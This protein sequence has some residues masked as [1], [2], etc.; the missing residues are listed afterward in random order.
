MHLTPLRTCRLF[1]YYFL[2]LAPCELLKGPPALALVPHM[3]GI[4][5]LSYCRHHHPWNLACTPSIAGVTYFESPATSQYLQKGCLTANKRSKFYSRAGPREQLSNKKRSSKYLDE[6]GKG[7]LQVWD[8]ARSAQIWQNNK[9]NFIVSCPQCDARRVKFCLD[10][11][12]WL[13][14]K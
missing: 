7:I 1:V 5:P 8:V 11:L 14:L 12:G 3:P 13:L 9:A 6:T 4:V 10:F 2:L